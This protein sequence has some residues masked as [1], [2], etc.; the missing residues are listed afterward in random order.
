MTITA[1]SKKILFPTDFSDEAQNAFEYTLQLAE[2]WGAN[3]ELLHVVYP[4]V[5]AL[6]Y[7]VLVTRATQELVD[8]GR[9]VLKTFIARSKAAVKEKLQRE[10]AIITDVE[11]GIPERVIR[12]I[13]RRD[14]ADIIIMGSRGENRSLMEQWLG[15]TTLGVVEKADCPV[16]VI[17]M[18]A[19]Y[20]G[21]NKIAYAT[22]GNAADAFEIWESLQLFKATANTKVEL[23]HVNTKTEGNAKAWA[24]MEQI[25]T[26]LQERE[27]GPQINLHHLVGSKV[28][29]E[30]NDFVQANQVDCL[31]MYRAY[32]HL[33]DRLFRQSQTR[34]MALKTQVPLLIQKEN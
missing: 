3:I 29:P 24:K 27:N 25:G 6:D 31:V 15:S 22:D 5:E 33:W 20:T 17:P 34:K 11:V 9:E 13:A 32:H 2:A 19:K 1:K 8:T 10:P 4:Q 7:P 23:V 26:F 16:L 21:I 14:S 30:L 12:E 18:E 28:E